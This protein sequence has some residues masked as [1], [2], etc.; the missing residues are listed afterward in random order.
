LAL[1]MG[2]KEARSR[3]AGGANVLLG[4][5]SVRFIKSTVNVVSWQAVGTRR[6]GEVVSADSF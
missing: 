2:W 3:H 1:S 6:G 5:G 4:D